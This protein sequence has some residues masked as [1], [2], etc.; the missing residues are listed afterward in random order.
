MDIR[1]FL[2]LL[3]GLCWTIVYIDSIR[4]GIKDKSYAMPLW[5]LALNIAWELIYA[6][7]GFREAGLQ[8]QIVINGVWFLL[9][10]G[11]VYTYFRYGRKY[12]PKNLRSSWFYLWSVLVFTVSFILQYTFFIEFGWFLGA[13]YAAYLQNLLMSVLFI[14]MLV[15]R[16]NSE[17]QTLTIAVSKWIGSLA[18]T[19]SFGMLGG[20]PSPQAKTFVLI[21]GMLMAFFDIVYIALLVNQKGF[22]AK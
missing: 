2:T 19:I 22:K 16:R 10:T 17:G 5:A 18:P 15:Q 21:V 11:I 7:V 6:V 9:D 1:L 4:V 3:S 12:F 14:A 8:V 20:G 13:T